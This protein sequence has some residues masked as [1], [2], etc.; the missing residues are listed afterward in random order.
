MISG[1]HSTEQGILFSQYLP[2]DKAV[3]QNVP[4][5]AKTGNRVAIQCKL[6]GQHCDT[7][8]RAPN[9]CQWALTDNISATK[10]FST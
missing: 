6:S 3:W 9:R 4:I 1:L 8:V 7:R 2:V 5:L 10:Y